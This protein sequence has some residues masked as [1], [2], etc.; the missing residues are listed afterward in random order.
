LTLASRDLVI[1]GAGAA[2]LAA[3]RVALACGLTVVV[4]EAKDRIGG[5]AH[6]DRTTFGV[7]WD[8]GAHWLHQ[9]RTNPFTA[10]AT[11]EGFAYDEVGLA[12]RLWSGGWAEPALQAELDD[13]YARAFAA[14]AAAGAAGLDVAASAVI[15][16]HP[17]FR[18]M[19]ES[20]SAAL[21]GADPDRVS[22]LDYAR[23]ELTSDNWRVIDGFGTLVERFGRGLPVELATRAERICWGGR[24][25]M[26]DTARGGLR[27][28]AAIV[29]V[30]TN[31]LA[32][33]RIALEPALPLRHH[34]AL[35]AVPVGEANKL[36]LAFEG[37]LAG[38]PGS[39]FVHFEH[40][41]REAM[42]LE[43]RPFGR[44][45]VIGYVGGRFAAE[46]EAAG[47]D[48]MAAFATDQLT[49]VFGER[50]RRQIRKAATTAWVGD[51]DIMGGYSCALP[52]KADL[53]PVLAEPLG[54]RVFFAGEAC[55]LNA[56]GTVHG[57][58]ASGEAAARA[59]ARVLNAPLA[60]ATVAPR[61]RRSDL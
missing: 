32:R 13:Y 38:P 7:P 34:E 17:R 24:E 3:A 56:F 53:R 35:A 61:R 20:W 23:Y 55:S 15:P 60:A 9:A 14:V 26:I 51:P 49:E 6:T 41:T 47:A 21:S 40:R 42:R 58:R 28:R 48:A 31:V 19:F 43:I 11:A 44:D 33:G 54:E 12:R 39:Y 36:A 29:T 59:V 30:S 25:V 18:A 16:P 10:F 1:V 8:R 4:L 50:V 22:T 37:D 57:A 27:C 46:L 5:R 45:L 2:G 52:G